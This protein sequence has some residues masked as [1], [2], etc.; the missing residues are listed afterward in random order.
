MRK[1]I[2]LVKVLLKSGGLISNNKQRKARWWVPL[3]LLVAFASFA[4]SVGMMATGLYDVLE[5]AGMA[6]ALLPLAMR[7]TS[8]MIFL[9]GVFYVVSVMYHADDVPLLM[10][11]PLRPYQM[12]AAKFITLVLYE[13]IF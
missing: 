7:A 4:L 2:V 8:V 3:V 10:A 6:G 13:Y 12:L 5:P 9:F 11:L 1:I